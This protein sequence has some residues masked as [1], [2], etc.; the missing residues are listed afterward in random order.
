MAPSRNRG[1]FHSHPRTSRSRP[2]R[3]AVKLALTNDS[4]TSGASARNQPKAHTRTH[5]KFRGF[6]GAP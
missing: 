5:T 2:D 3:L 1:P 6:V 4:K